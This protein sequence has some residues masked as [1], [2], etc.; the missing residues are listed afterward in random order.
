MKDMSG[1]TRKRLTE[2]GTVRQ[3]SNSKS[4][5]ADPERG[6]ELG[7]D[8][9]SSGEVPPL[10]AQYGSTSMQHWPNGEA[11]SLEGRGSGGSNL[12]TDLPPLPPRGWE[13]LATR[14]TSVVRFASHARS[15][16]GTQYP[17]QR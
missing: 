6:G 4:A 9:L 3:R 1:P 2:L 5:A 16:S 15:A 12:A 14:Q 8:E 7:E 11:D 10:R 13:G 17:L